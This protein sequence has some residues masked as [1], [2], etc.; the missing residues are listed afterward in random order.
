MKSDLKTIRSY[1]DQMDP[2]VVLPNF[3]EISLGLKVR[4]VWVFEREILV[5]DNQFCNELMSALFVKMR[6]PTLLPGYDKASEKP[7]QLWSNGAE[8][9]LV[10][11]KPMSWNIVFGMAADV[12]AKSE[13]GR[14]EIP[15][16]LIAGEVEKR[17]PGRWQ[18]EFELGASGVRFWDATADCPS[19]CQVKPDG[20]LCFT[21]RAG[22]AKWGEILGFG[23]VNAQ[24]ALNL[25]NAAGETYFDGHRYWEFN[26]G[27]WYDMIR[28]DINLRLKTRGIASKT[29]KGQTVSDV[30]RV[31]A[32]IQMANRIDGAATLINF[33][34]GIVNLYGS[35]ILNTSRLRRL[36]PVSKTQVEPSQDFPWLWDFLTGLFDRRDLNSVE[37]FLAWLKRAYRAVLEFE[38]LMGQCVFLCGPHNNGK[39]LLCAHIIKPLLGGVMAN[40]YKYFV[41]ETDFNS[42]LFEAALWAM[43]DE[44]S[45]SDERAKRKLQ[46]KLKA[47]TVNPEHTFHPKFQK[48]VSIPWTGRVFITLNDDPASVGILPEVNCNTAD[49]LMFFASLPYAAEWGERRETE[50]RIAAELPYFAR[51][52]LDI[53]KPPAEIVVGGRMGVKSFFDP[54]ILALSEQQN[55]A[56]NLLE[57][58][59]TWCK[60]APAFTDTD[61]DKWEGT[62][63][64]LLAHIAMADHLVPLLRDWTVPKLA[65]SLTALARTNSSGITFVE[66]TDSRR[67]RLVRNAILKT[68]GP[69]PA[70]T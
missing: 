52:L 11:E 54:R 4:L 55:Y 26:C 14:S 56:Y 64:D 21:G 5:R 58:V 7:T 60:D 2:A 62:P 20:M 18:G 63:S 65:K 36:E 22:F 50:A 19:G 40:P 33:R 42:E 48:K 23:W 15:I 31:L 17:F 70:T 66:G 47:V 32:H 69:K 45:P 16:E 28:L 25:T 38:P 41:G 61:T 53:Y 46:V 13:S 3:V 67:F 35:R 57:L 49:K 27:R 1:L 10:N 30:D 37:F 44:D 39:T 43:N 8:W 68:E 34:P 24:R 29:A 6:V 51:W 59:A 9:H 12:G